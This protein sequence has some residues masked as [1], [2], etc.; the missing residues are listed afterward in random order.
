M[1]SDWRGC[2]GRNDSLEKAGFGLFACWYTVLGRGRVSVADGLSRLCVQQCLPTP[3]RRRSV[4]SSASCWVQLNGWSPHS[5]SRPRQAG[6]RRHAVST[7]PPETQWEPE[8]L[9]GSC[10][11]SKR[12]FLPKRVG[13]LFK[14]SDN[15]HVLLCWKLFRN[16][17]KNTG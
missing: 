3:A 1:I 2:E 16:F 8:L 14:I 6:A 15:Y 4:C 7:G 9:W 5:S 13:M 11:F 10:R 17:A 12:F